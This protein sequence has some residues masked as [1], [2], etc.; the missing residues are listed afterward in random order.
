M[1]MTDESEASDVGHGMSASL[2]GGNSCCRIRGKHRCHCGLVSVI[3][4]D[5][6]LESRG[7]D[8]HPQRL[9]EYEDIAWLRSHVGQRFAINDFADDNL[10][11]KGLCSID[12]VSTDGDPTAGGCRILSSEQNFAEKVKWQCVARPRSNVESKQWRATHGKNVAR[13]VGGGNGSEGTGV[14]DDRG[15]EVDGG[16]KGATIWSAPHC[17][18]V[19]GGQPNYEVGMTNRLQMAQDLRQVARTELASST[20]AVAVGRKPDLGALVGHPIVGVG[21]PPRLGGAVANWRGRSWIQRRSIGA[22]RIRR[23]QCTP[24][25]RDRSAQPDCRNFLTC[26]TRFPGLALSMQ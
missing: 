16:D 25:R 2:A 20:G 7:D 26:T 24:P 12:G 22:K 13:R 3:G 4:G 21:H 15:H 9:G 17:G 11:E 1:E 5:P 18:V 19:S 6:S 23:L 14:V 8:A 10:A